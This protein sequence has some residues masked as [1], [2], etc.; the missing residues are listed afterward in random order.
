MTPSQRLTLES[1][2]HLLFWAVIFSAVNV[3]W[4]RN[5]FDASIRPDTP[6]PLSVLLFPVLFYAH[7]YWALPAFLVSRKWMVYGFRLILLFVAPEVIRLLAYQIAFGRPIY[8]ELSSRDSFL[9]GGLNT[10]WLAFLVSFIF[11]LAKDRFDMKVAIQTRLDDAEAT[12]IRNALE[13]MMEEEKPYLNKDLDLDSLASR[14]NITDK[15]LS[16]LLNQHVQT[17]FSDYVNAYRVRQ[18]IDQVDAGALTTLSI[19]GLADQC[20][21]SSKTTFY[22]AFK[23]V[24]GC[25]PSEFVVSNRLLEPSEQA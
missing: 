19:A 25:T 7:A 24:K 3:E 20:G 1:T 17:G 4:Q 12:L 5:W 14:L 22:R 11:R 10:I 2:L 21:F 18:F 16:T 6:S 9:F 15:K 13:R 8:Q 23:K